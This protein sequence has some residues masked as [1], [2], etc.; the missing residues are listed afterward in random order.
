MKEKERI[1]RADRQ[2]L[3]RPKSIEGSEIKNEYYINGKFE[4]QNWKERETRLE[5]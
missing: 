4:Y 3:K 5:Q 1:L 2:T